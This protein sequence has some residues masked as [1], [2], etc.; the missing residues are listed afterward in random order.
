MGWFISCVKNE[1]YNIIG[2]FIRVVLQI[3]Y[4]TSFIFL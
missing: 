4:S 1:E 3:V 2:W